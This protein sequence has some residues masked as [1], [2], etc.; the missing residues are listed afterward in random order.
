[1]SSSI[2]R[3]LTILLAA[4]LYIYNGFFFI[5]VLIAVLSLISLA[6]FKHNPK[7]LGVLLWVLSLA[8]MIMVFHI[9]KYGNAIEIVIYN[10]KLLLLPIVAYSVIYGNISKFMLYIIS[11]ALIGSIVLAF[12]QAQTNV[13][14]IQYVMILPFVAILMLF[15]E[16]Q[17]YLKAILLATTSLIIYYSFISE[18]R[19]AMLTV[20]VSAFGIALNIIRVARVSN[21]ININFSK[22]VIIAFFLNSAI[23]YFVLSVSPDE[24][25]SMGLYSKPNYERLSLLSLAMDTFLDGWQGSGLQA[26]QEY[27]SRAFILSDGSYHVASSTHNQYVDALFQFGVPGLI[28][29]I[30]A[31]FYPIWL[32]TRHV[33]CSNNSFNLIF[34]LC[35]I[36]AS[37]FMPYNDV[38]RSVYLASLGIIVS[39]QQSRGQFKG[40]N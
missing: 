40:T 32:L 35:I 15:T 7:N 16:I 19:L 20:I 10:A 29:Y 11:G 21:V 36:L 13:S 5:E 31:T 27:L 9:Y 38:Y 26:S 24:L 23:I 33:R 18:Y 4:A 3:I 2:S 28:S 6:R 12:N 25:W 1:M 17:R 34:I 37:S 22:S 14:A 8:S 30:L 39:I